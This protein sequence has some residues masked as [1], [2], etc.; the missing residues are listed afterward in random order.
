MEILPINRRIK[1]L[2]EKLNLSQT[3]FGDT[4]G[5]KH[6]TIS[7]IE[8]GRCPVTQ[9]TATIIYTKFYVSQKWLLNGIGDIFVSEDKKY[10]EFFEV[11]KKL[12]PPL[13]EFIYQTAKNLL[14]TQNLL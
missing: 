7:D 8:R 10:N 3:A 13:Q 2:R 5:L 9:R 1:I 11:Y 4:I 6:S 14:E 12:S